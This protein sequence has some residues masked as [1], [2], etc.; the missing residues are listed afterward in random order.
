MAYILAVVELSTTTTGLL[1]VADMAGI[2]FC[3]T[4]TTAGTPPAV[5]AGFTTTRRSGAVAEERSWPRLTA[6]I[7]TAVT[8]S[9]STTAGLT[10]A[11]MELS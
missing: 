3:R 9:R 6:L 1:S 11:A 7:L 4:G 8:I 10:T 2:S 5:E